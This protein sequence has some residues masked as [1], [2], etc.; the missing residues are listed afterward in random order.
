MPQP[1]APALLGPTGHEVDN[2]KP[3]AKVPVEISRA[4]HLALKELRK[5]ALTDGVDLTTLVSDGSGDA[6]DTDTDTP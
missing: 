1:I 6:S 2:S 4:T 3:Q 5:L